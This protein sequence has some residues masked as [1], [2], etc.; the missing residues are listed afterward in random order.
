MIF[1]REDLC[2]MGGRCATNSSVRGA[3]APFMR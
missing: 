3:A 1:I 2:E